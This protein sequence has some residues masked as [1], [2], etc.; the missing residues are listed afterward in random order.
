MIGILYA[1]GTAL[2]FIGLDIRNEYEKEKYKAQH[3]ES[4]YCWDRRGRTYDSKTGRRVSLERDDWTGSIYMCDVKTGV[5]YKNITAPKNIIKNKK[6]IAKGATAVPSPF[7][8][9]EREDANGNKI[10]WELCDTFAPDYDPE[11]ECTTGRIYIKR[12]NFTWPKENN[13]FKYY[14]CDRNYYV[15]PYVLIDDKGNKNEYVRLVR[16]TD[17]QR[18]TDVK[19][20]RGWLNGKKDGKYRIWSKT[21]EELEREFDFR[22]IDEFV[23][24][25][26]EK[27]LIPLN[28]N[29]ILSV[30]KKNIAED[31]GAKLEATIPNKAGWFIKEETSEMN[32]TDEDY[33][34]LKEW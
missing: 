11:S 14:H 25:E 9:K 13:R 33:E 12:I 3:P 19:R 34:L 4:P 26:S 28:R 8:S 32:M 30:P 10:G 31:D 27:Y 15:K 23:I 24:N 18:V 20:K 22:A 16:S 29:S 6:L 5:K 2:R 1:L 17:A 7:F 21:K